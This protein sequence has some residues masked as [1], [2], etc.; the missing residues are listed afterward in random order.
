MN[1]IRSYDNYNFIKTITGRALVASINLEPEEECFDIFLPKRMG[2]FLGG[3]SEISEFL[4]NI[5]GFSIERF[6]H[7]SPVLKFHSR[8]RSTTTADV[9]VRT[10]RLPAEDSSSSVCSICMSRQKDTAF[11]CGH[12][13]C[14]M[15][16]SRISVCFQC[17]EQITR[18]IRIYQ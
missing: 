9:I 15:C 6:E 5:G 7:G 1:N 11:L 4:R 17:R 10:P 16:A 14:G 8:A 12:T 13:C 3:D 18:R 2:A